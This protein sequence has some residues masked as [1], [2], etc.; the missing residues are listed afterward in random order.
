MAHFSSRI[1]K[2]GKNVDKEDGKRRR[3]HNIIINAFYEVLEKTLTPLLEIQNLRIEP[4]LKQDFV[5][6]L[7]IAK[8]YKLDLEDSLHLSVAIRTGCE[9]IISNDKDFDKT[10]L[11]RIF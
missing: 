8:K 11:K 6:A 7:S 3:V 1:W 9:S 10:E 5:N 2:E 4:L